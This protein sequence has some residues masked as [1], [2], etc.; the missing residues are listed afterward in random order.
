[1]GDFFARTVGDNY[2]LVDFFVTEL[3]YYEILYNTIIC[4]AHVEFV[5]EINFVVNIFL[6][7]L[8]KINKVFSR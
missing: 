2:S 3:N 7:S 5:K 8:R 6:H 4:S 1:M